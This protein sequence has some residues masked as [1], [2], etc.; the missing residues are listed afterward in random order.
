LTSLGERLRH[1]NWQV[2]DEAVRDA[3]AE[4][5]PGEAELVMALADS[6]ETRQV[7][8]VAALG[9]TRGDT[10]PAALRKVLSSTKRD[11]LCAALL[12]LAKR[13]G[14][15]ASAD[16]ASALAG[17]DS[18]VKNYAMLGLA[19]AGDDR[20]WEAAFNRLK[21]LLRRPGS[22][23]SLKSQFLSVQSPVAAAIC[24]LGRHLD[25]QGGSRTIRLVQELRGHWAQVGSGEQGWLAEVW[26]TCAP[27][28]PD[29]AD[30][31]EPDGQRLQQWIR[32]PLFRP[33][34]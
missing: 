20:A 11:V 24:Y 2:F 30:V 5:E 18:A 1:R 6:P 3:V 25:G 29:G 17:R 13:S 16:L 7:A 22:P 4:G 27:G 34:F 21:Q 12:A 9:D 14:P 19:G 15:A 10:A 28:G 23:P 31:P 8:I 33:L 26:P 32:D